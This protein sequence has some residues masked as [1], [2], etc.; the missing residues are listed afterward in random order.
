LLNIS[1]KTK[2]VGISVLCVVLL[3]LFSVLNSRAVF[4]REIDRLYTLDYRERIGNFLWEYETIDAVSAASEEVARLQETLLERLRAR[5]LDSSDVRGDTFIFNGEGKSILADGLVESL[6]AES[7]LASRVQGRETGNFVLTHDETEYWVIFS[8]YEPWDWYTGYVLENAERLEA[9]RTSTRSLVIAA[10]A[11]VVLLTLG[12][13]VYLGRVLDPLKQASITLTEVA[14]G[15]LT[16]SLQVKTKDEVG[17]IASSFNTLV[18]GLKGILLGI[19]TASADTLAQSRSLGEKTLAAQ[20][21]LDEVKG[22]AT[23]IRSRVSGLQD[24]VLQSNRSMERIAAAMADLQAR[25]DDQFAAVTESSAAV[26]EMS[27]SLGNVANI[28][29]TKLDS[30]N[31]LRENGRVGAEKVSDTSEAIREIEGRVSDISAFVDIIAGIA[32]QTNLLSM[33]AA[34]EAAHAGESGKGFAVVAEEIRKLAEVA[35]EQSAQISA[36][37]EGIA[38]KTT[39]A[40]QSGRAADAFFA[41]LDEAIQE[42]V[43]SFHEIAGSTSEL[44]S[45]S[46]EINKAISSLNDISVRVKERSDETDKEVR[47]VVEVIQEVRNLA[48]QVSSEIETIETETTR[49][50]AD[51]NA[52]VEIGRNLTASMDRLFEQVGRYQT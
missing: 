3:A 8:Y 42:V 1:L 34:I 13:V 14:R 52:I 20:S 10:S 23:S 45:G 30:T 47:S 5:Y 11:A 25:I 37:I 4:L 32:D 50:Q 19:Q 28:A 33:N 15:D 41:D 21:Q 18:D 6:L 29:R 36:V 51:V 43:D 49:S 24:S 17:D 2:I 22:N 48:Q 46:D 44:S 7:N 27:A 12:Y 35:G 16:Q 39:A 9:V 38:E 40:S 26:E 31:A